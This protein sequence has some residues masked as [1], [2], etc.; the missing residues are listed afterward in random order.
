[1]GNGDTVITNTS[2]SP[3][4][5]IGASDTI[6]EPGFIGSGDT[7]HEIVFR[8]AETLP[9]DNYQIDIFGACASPLLNNAGEPF[10]DGDNLSVSFA[11]NLAP[12]VLAV[13]PTPVENVSSGV[14][15]LA[16]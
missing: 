12:E 15:P 14:Q 7:R 9:E 5:L 1:M 4:R 6:V 13:V 11:I 8:F 10:N 2:F 16:T 3:L